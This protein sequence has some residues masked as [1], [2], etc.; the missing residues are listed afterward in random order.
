MLNT[1]VN[2][3][4]CDIRTSLKNES[5]LYNSAAF[6]T[7]FSYYALTC[8]GP[9]VPEISLYSSKNR[10]K[11]ET[12]ENNEELL[13]LIEDKLIPIT[14]TFTVPLEDDFEAYVQLK[15]PPNLDRSGDT[16]YPMIVNV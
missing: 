15:L 12:W 9:G 14:Q 7:D 5:C 10:I 3:L 4:S 1:T 11:L 13:E 2:C 8:D 6:S 16:K